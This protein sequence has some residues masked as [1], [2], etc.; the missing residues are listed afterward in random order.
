MNNQN[1]LL[2]VS[3]PR[4]LSRNK[5][6]FTHLIKNRESIIKSQLHF[7]MF[8]AVSLKLHLSLL[9]FFPNLGKQ[10]GKPWMLHFWSHSLTTTKTQVHILYLFSQATL[11]PILGPIWSTWKPHYM[12]NVFFQILFGVYEWECVCVITGL[13]TWTK[14]GMVMVLKRRTIQESIPMNFTKLNCQWFSLL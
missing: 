1:K 6:Q 12:R 10:K 8:I 11:G 7:L 13:D 3:G 5:S 14:I 4:N 9:P 2:R